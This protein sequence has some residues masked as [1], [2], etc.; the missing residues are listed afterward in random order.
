M[1]HTTLSTVKLAIGLVIEIVFVA[2]AETQPNK[3][4]ATKVTKKFPALR[5]V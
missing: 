2:G 5:N 1:S 3:S 4:V